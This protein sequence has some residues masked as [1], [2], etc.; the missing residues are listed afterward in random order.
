M[1]GRSLPKIIRQAP[2]PQLSIV[3][4][5]TIPD[6]ARVVEQTGILRQEPPAPKE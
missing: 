6:F 4:E 5:K 3:S 1:T 2:E